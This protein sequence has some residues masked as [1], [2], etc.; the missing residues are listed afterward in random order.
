MIRNLGGR[1]VNNWLIPFRE[2]YILVDTGYEGGFSRFRKKLK[3]AGVA[4]GEIKYIFLTHAHDDHAGFLNGALAL[5]GA[6]VILHPKAVEGLKRGQNSF[7]GGC[8][9]RLAHVF[10]LLLALLGKGEHRY[11]P[12]REEYMDRLISIDSDA[13][14]ALDAPFGAVETPGHTEDHISL[15]MDGRLFCGDAAMNGF[16][17]RRRVI[18]WIGDLEKYRRSWEVML[19]TMAREAYPG[20]GKPFPLSDL[21][22]YL[23][24]LDRIRLYPLKPIKSIQKGET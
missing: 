16:P 18:I 7:E 6:K 10:C 17:S 8:S 1:A 2:G 5:T 24:E 19:D 12:I 14:R 9:G 21:K 20:H 11:P 3:R 22:K 23:P 4:P 13:F 15:L